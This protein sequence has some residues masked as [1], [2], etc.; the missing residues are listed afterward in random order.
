[1]TNSNDIKRLKKPKKAAKA[2]ITS[3]KDVPADLL[4]TK[5]TIWTATNLE[6]LIKFELSGINVTLFLGSCPEIRHL[7]ET[8]VTDYF[9]K[10]GLHV[11][12][13]K[14]IVL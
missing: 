6:T 11:K 3:I 9:T 8:G 4:Y 2:E 10:D 14:C 13:S 5:H 7:L 1:M 12:F